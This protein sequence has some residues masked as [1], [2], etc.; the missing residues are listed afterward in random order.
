MKREHEPRKVVGDRLRGFHELVV[1]DLLRPVVDDADARK[2]VPVFGL[3]LL[4]ALEEAAHRACPLTISQSTD[5]MRGGC[6]GVAS[7]SFDGASGVST[8]PSGFWN[9][10]ATYDGIGYSFSIMSSSET[11]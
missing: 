6:N 5:K 7:S 1:D 8:H 11:Q 3:T 9:T 2:L 10:S 4:S